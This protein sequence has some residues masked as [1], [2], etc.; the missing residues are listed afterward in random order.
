[1][2]QTKKRTSNSPHEALANPE[3]QGVTS[4]ADG[5]GSQP[6]QPDAKG[7][8]VALSNLAAPPVAQYDM[9]NQQVPV[10]DLGG[11]LER[12]SNN[13]WGYLD[14]ELT[15]NIRDKKEIFDIG[16]EVEVGAISKD[17][18]SGT[19]PWPAEQPAFE[20]VMR[21]HLEACER[22]SITMVEAICL[23]LWL[24]RAWLAANLS[25]AT[26]FLRLNYYPVQDPLSDLPVAQREG[27]DLGVHHN[28]DAGAVTILIQD[29]VGYLQV[30]KDGMWHGVKSI[31]GALVIKFGDMVQVWSNDEYRTTPIYGCALERVPTQTGRR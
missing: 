9:V 13:P 8:D 15:K 7:N 6:D 17:P 11:A 10:I 26:R 23:G 4:M 28:S 29:Q 19:T 3:R 1:M 24:L 30:L 21:A 14:R 31:E 18:F 22:L 27:T 16:P 2:A 12:S 25:P 5:L 20:A